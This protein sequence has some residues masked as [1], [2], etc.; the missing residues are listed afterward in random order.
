MVRVRFVNYVF[1]FRL[2][3]RPLG[4]TSIIWKVNHRTYLDRSSILPT[5][6][7]SSRSDTLRGDI[8]PSLASASPLNICRFATK[9]HAC[10]VD[11]CEA[12]PTHA[13]AQRLLLALST[14]LSALS[15]SAWIYTTP[16][17]SITLPRG[18][19]RQPKA[20]GQGNCNLDPTGKLLQC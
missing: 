11:S 3:P 10:T 12:V 18:H 5:T 20:L 4:P 2:T 13:S 9:T 6:P 19:R 16:A 8:E 1:S 7:P 15:R 17:R 14:L